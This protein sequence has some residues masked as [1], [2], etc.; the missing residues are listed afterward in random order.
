VSK[1]YER[2]PFAWD[3]EG[4]RVCRAFGIGR[5]G[6]TPG[7]EGKKE[8]NRWFYAFNLEKL[9]SGMGGGIQK[10]GNLTEN[11][12]SFDR[13]GKKGRKRRR[14]GDEKM[15]GEGD[16][17]SETNG[18]IFSFGVGEESERDAKTGRK[19]SKM[20]GKGRVENG[21]P[22]EDYVC[23]IC[24]SSGHWI[25]N[26]PKKEERDG[27]R[28]RGQRDQRDSPR[29]GYVCHK[30]GLEGHYIKDCPQRGEI[31]RE[32]TDDSTKSQFRC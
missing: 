29:K 24:D 32:W 6:N 2:E 12:F 3:S 27:K 16:G 17:E 4:Q 25:K 28:E 1:F 18:M 7:G 30:C 19:K 15:N 10:I 23:K 20:E 21:S 13:D 22:P 14:D 5:F 26:C 11:P 9:E 8:K 31:A